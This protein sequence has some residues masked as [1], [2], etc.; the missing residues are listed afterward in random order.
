MIYHGVP[1]LGQDT[2]DDL[3]YWFLDDPDLIIPGVRVSVAEITRSIST[4]AYS[5]ETRGTLIAGNK[6]V[7]LYDA[8]PRAWTFQLKFWALSTEYDQLLF[9][10]L[11]SRKTLYFRTPNNSY[12]WY[13]CL[14]GDITTEWLHSPDEFGS[15]ITRLTYVCNAQEV[16]AP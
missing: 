3:D 8:T 14:V 12:F 11:T 2:D 13:V 16:D 1:Q 7:V 4:A 5:F 9:A 10:L 15:M 6:P